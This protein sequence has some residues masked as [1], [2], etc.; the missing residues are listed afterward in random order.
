MSKAIRSN[1]EFHWHLRTIVVNAQA[2]CESTTLHRKYFVHRALTHD[3]R[4]EVVHNE[5]LVLVHHAT[6]SFR[7]DLS[8]GPQRL[9]IFYLVNHL[10]V[11]ANEH[12]MDAGNDAVFVIATVSNNCLTITAAWKIASTGVGAAREERT[13]S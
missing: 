10:V 9:F 2:R 4:Q 13:N 8:I 11:E 1:A 5:Q 12:G 6:A 3:A 7:K